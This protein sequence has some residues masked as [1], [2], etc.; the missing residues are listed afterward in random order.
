[1]IAVPLYHMIIY[2]GII[3]MP[4]GN[5]TAEA[6]WFC[7]GSAIMAD[8]AFMAMSAY[9]F[10]NSSGKPIVSK[11]LELGFQVLGLYVFKIFMIR[12]VLG[13][14]EIDYFVEDFFIKGAWWFIYAYLI[15]LLIYPILNRVVNHLKESQLFFVC[16]FIGAVFVYNGLRNDVNLFHDVIAFLFTYC[17]VAYLKRTG[18]KKYFGINNKKNAMISIYVI[19]YLATF[20]FLWWVKY[21]GNISSDDIASDIVR[22]VV[23]KYSFVQFVMGVA[24]FLLFHSIQMKSNKWINSIAKNV[25]YVFLLHETVMAIYW[26]FGKMRTIDDVIPYQDITQ[27]IVWAIIYISSSFLFAWGI[28]MIYHLLF[29]RLVEMIVAFICNTNIIKEIELRYRKIEEQ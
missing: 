26:Y 16:M 29:K 10:L 6:L 2:A 7:S 4:Y 14:P 1:M 18:F 13:F 3:Y 11:F 20:L 23:G 21:P 25:F 12:K 8:Y 9:F 5:M 19:G 24:V 28:R 15:M 22:C 17:V 27:L